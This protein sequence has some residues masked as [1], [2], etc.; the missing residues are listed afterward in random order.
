MKKRTAAIDFKRPIDQAARLTAHLDHRRRVGASAKKTAHRNPRNWVESR[1]VLAKIRNSNIEITQQPRQRATY[2]Q[3]HS[4]S[5]IK[6]T[7]DR[8]FQPPRT[9]EAG[10]MQATRRN[11][12]TSGKPATMATHEGNRLSGGAPEKPQVER[13]MDMVDAGE[14]S[15]VDVQRSGKTTRVSFAAPSEQWECNKNGQRLWNDTSEPVSAPGDCRSRMERTVRQ[16]ACEATQLHQTIDRMARMLEA[17]AARDEAQWLGMR[18]WLQ[19]RETKWDE[20]HKD[21]VLWGTGIADMTAEVLAKARVWEV[22]PAQEVRKEGRDETAMQDRGG[23]GAS[24]HAG[25]T[26]DGE[27]EK[28]QLL[29]QQQN[30]KPKLQLTLQPEPRHKPEPKPKPTPVPG[31]RWE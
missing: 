31:K 13:D 9:T 16:Q 10:W 4:I 20:R 23:L 19:D 7:L 24:Q 22:A 2:G 29:Q 27:P 14:T 6:L 26:P 17:Q 5:N 11:S 18:E 28:R 30:P 12:T 8:H 3:G 25:A 21:N 15:G 1:K